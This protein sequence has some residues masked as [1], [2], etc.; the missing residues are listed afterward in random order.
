MARIST[1]ASQTGEVKY[2][3]PIFFAL[4]IAYTNATPHLQET[5]YL[6][7]RKIA[8]ALL[9]STTTAVPLILELKG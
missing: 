6:A 2:I 4:W 9:L 3:D 1:I 5:V 8:G 7:L